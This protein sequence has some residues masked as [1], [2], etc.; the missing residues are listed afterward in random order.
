[1]KRGANRVPATFRRELFLPEM[2]LA[3]V[4]Q[5]RLPDPV[6]RL[7]LHIPQTELVT[8][9]SLH[10]LLHA[11][12]SGPGDRLQVA[13]NGVTVGSSVMSS[14]ISEPRSQTG[15]GASPSGDRVLTVDV[16]L[17]PELMV[18]DNK[19]EL[20]L[21]CGGWS[22][23]C[24]WSPAGRGRFWLDPKSSVRLSGRRVS[25][26]D[27]LSI[28][29]LPFSD[30]GDAADG[31]G[32]VRIVFGSAPSTEAL[33]AGGIIASWLGA[34][35]HGE[36]PRLVSHADRIPAGNVILLLE[37]PSSLWPQQPTGPG[38]TLSIGTNPMDSNAKLLVLSA[39]SSEKLL[40][41]ARYLIASTGSLHGRLQRLQEA[42]A[43]QEH[44]PANESSVG[45]RLRSDRSLA[46]SATSR[47]ATGLQ[48]LEF[49]LGLAAGVTACCWALAYVLRGMLRERAESRLRMQDGE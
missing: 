40:D 6:Q 15:S 27:D 30:P 46:A 16:Q 38:A 41:A 12:P 21:T 13:L 44:R 10:L 3:S 23:S 1:M 48:D 11:Q 2:Q 37:K 25:L 8:S 20:A 49:G 31:A 7:S 32:T 45:Y 39:H 33:E 28:L 18:S 9:A 42:G 36:P 34:V 19:L 5:T 47:S 26:P 22:G 43:W 24:E 29:P 4:D 35:S 14:V 17:A